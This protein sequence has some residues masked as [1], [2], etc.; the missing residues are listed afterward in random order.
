MDDRGHTSFAS[1]KYLPTF[2]LSD[3]DRMTGVDI[4]LG[5][6]F[7]CPLSSCHRLRKERARYVLS[8]DGAKLVHWEGDF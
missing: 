4:H 7:C 1:S 8:T 3:F 6:R 2:N 5:L